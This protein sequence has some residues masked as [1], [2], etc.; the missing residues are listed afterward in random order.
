MPETNL[1]KDKY[2]EI[3]KQIDVERTL[4]EYPN[5]DIENI[6]CG[7]AKLIYWKCDKCHS[8]PAQVYNR[9][10]L[11]SKCPYCCNQKVLPGFNDLQTRYP[12]IAEEFAIDLNGITPDKVLSGS[13]KKYF[14]R[15]SKNPEHVWEATLNQRTNKH[16]STGCP[17]CYNEKPKSEVNIATI[18][19]NDLKTLCPEIFKEIDKERTLQ[20]YP[21]LKLEKLSYKSG[22]KIFWRCKH[23]HQW[24]AKVCNRSNGSE[25]PVCLNQKLLTG[26]NDLQSRYPEI[27]KEWDYA[28]NYPVTPDKVLCGT[29]KKYWWKCKHG[30]SWRSSVSSRTFSGHKCKKCSNHHSTPELLFHYIIKNNFDSNCINGF[31]IMRKEFDEYIPL[32][33]TLAEYDGYYYHSE[34]DMLAESQKEYKKKNET[35]KDNLALINNYKIMHICETKNIEKIK[36]FHEVKNG[37]SYYYINSYYDD[38]YFITFS[39]IFLEEFQLKIKSKTIKNLF[40]TIR[41]NKEV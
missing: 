13:H 12:K 17:H 7:S 40:Y 35:E 36:K 20:K 30:H 15:C 3:F 37:V 19:V 24:E 16:H 5:L 33:N 22:L 23:G 18:G 26:F 2:P 34:S 31:K 41:K 10:K 21:N 11:S 4:Q 25:C 27:A 28:K 29:G 39:K 32:I 1:L 14:W 38:N 8:W 6:T 9:T